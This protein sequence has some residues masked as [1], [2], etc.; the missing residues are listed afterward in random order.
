MS[1]NRT[2]VRTD[3]ITIPIFSTMLLLATAADVIAQEDSSYVLEEVVVTAQ[4]REQN[5]QEIPVSVTAI[6]GQDLEVHQ[7]NNMQDIRSLVPNLYV[8]EGLSGRTT[9]KM[10]MRGIGVSNQNFSF[11]API[12]IYMDGVY[13]ARATGALVDLFD[14]ERVEMLRGPQGTLYGRNNSVGALRIETKKASL[15]D[16]DAKADF[17]V[18]S[19]DQRNLRL[20]LGAPLIED[21]LGVRFA[22]NTRN[23]DGW[24]R[25]MNTGEP[26]KEDDLSAGRIQLRYIPND[27]L[28]VILR[29]DYMAD[30]G[31]GT[32]AS[33][34]LVDPD[35]D[36][37]TFESSI[38]RRSDIDTWGASGTINWTSPSS[39]IN[40]TSISAYRELKYRNAE[41]VDGL[42]DVRSFEV[43]RQDQDEWQFTQELYATGDSFGALPLQWVLGAFY[44][45][46]RNEFDWAVQIFA[47]PTVQ[48]FEQDTDSA[49][50]YGQAIYPL[51]DRLSLTTGIRYTYE[52][53]EF[54][55]TQVLADGTPNPA[56]DF[57]DDMS[58]NEVTWRAAVDFAATDSVLLYASAATGFRSGGFNGNAIARSDIAGGGFGVEDSFTIEGGV[59]SELFEN[60]LR[61]N[62]NYFYTE[63]DNLQQAI[64][65]SDGTIATSNSQ[66][67][68]HGL[69]AELK[70]LPAKGLAI[71]VT[72]GSMFDDIKDSDLTLSNAPEWSFRVDG[73]Y[74]FRVPGLAGSLRIAG[75]VSYR[76]NSFTG[77]TNNPFSA[78][79]D[80]EIVNAN[81]TYE[82]DDQHWALTLAGFN[83]SD[84]FVKTHTFIVAGGAIASTYY[85]N[86]PRHWA[87][88]LKYQY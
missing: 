64:T 23:N 63:Y 8:E 14:I 56:Y 72:L 2:N 67:T 52:K 33:N 6:S 75:D 54:T 78:T 28:E 82:T 47:P 13:Y 45:R 24:Q 85:P 12:G 10:H 49:A 17:T 88:T 15:T 74:T 59:K 30:R 84:Q 38:D 36:I 42:A 48:T 34:F 44:F 76:T 73:A 65:R 1:Q 87:L 11:D 39:A 58:A 29:G 31:T 70:A 77:G 61:L 69:E 16:F 20:A 50:V 21:K 68:V 62:M 79:G 37:Y 7:I 40:V 66:A 80:Y 19:K 43:A 3:V 41:D 46:E 53:K 18:G 60:K 81:L 35:D 32:A 71:G 22:F 57:F 27:Q 9:V 4:K 25:D 83:L 26:A 51:S 5:L 55:G 86:T